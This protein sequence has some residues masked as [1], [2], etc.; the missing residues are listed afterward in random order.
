[1]ADRSGEYARRYYYDKLFRQGLGLWRPKAGERVVIGTDP[2]RVGTV[3]WV[4]G[5]LVCVDTAKRR[6]VRMEF[7]VE[8][9][10]VRPLPS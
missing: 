1:M 8:V 7:T 3:V 5:N 2:R 10:Q 4:R 6:N 9:E